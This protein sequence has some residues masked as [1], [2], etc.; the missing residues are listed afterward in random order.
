MRI[1][2]APLAPESEFYASGT[3][4]SGP[5]AF[6]LILGIW[7]AG[8]QAVT[9][10]RIDHGDADAADDLIP[11]RSSIFAQILDMVHELGETQCHNLFRDFVNGPR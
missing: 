5:K 3:F 1:L 9:R 6:G 10:K 2:S 7:T 4:S 11:E 8:A